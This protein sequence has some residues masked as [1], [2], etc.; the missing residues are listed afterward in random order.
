MK[1]ER[2]KRSFA[3]TVKTLIV[4]A[5]LSLFAGTVQQAAGK[6]LNVVTTLPDYAQFVKAIGA[7]HVKVEYIVQPV[8]DPHHVR[9][10]PSFV[11]M[12]KKADMVVSTGL[13]LEMWLPTVID[14]SGN[15]KIRSGEDGFVSV[16]HNMK[17]VEKPT[18]YSQAL[19]DVHVEG[20]PHFTCSPI[21]M[22]QAAANIYTGLVKND[23]ERV[24]FYKNNLERLQRKIDEKLFGADLVQLFSKKPGLLS[25]LAAQDKLIPFLRKN[26]LKGEPL[27]DRLGGWMKKML[28]LRNKKIVVYHKNWSYFLQL[29]GLRCAGTIEP[30]PGIPPSAQHIVSLVELMKAEDV[31]IIFA[32][33]YFDK[34]KVEMVAKKVNAEPVIVPLFVGGSEETDSYFKLVDFWVDG[35][36]DAARKTKVIE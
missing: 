14:K 28:P 31:R 24:D 11:W 1:G 4:I 6:P 9:P 33:N 23:K 29:F 13:D 35:L 34:Q 22:R 3:C 2:M 19:G 5:G 18:V 32:A 27:I 26:S 25:R 7:D 17:L 36:V 16:S 21:C 10:K 30:K 15:R 20:N 12:V 8:Q